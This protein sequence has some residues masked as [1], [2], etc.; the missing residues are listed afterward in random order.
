LF[1]D[2]AGKTQTELLALYTDKRRQAM[3]YQL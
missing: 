2:N 1:Y 3:Q